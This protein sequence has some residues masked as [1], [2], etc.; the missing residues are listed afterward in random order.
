MRG[1]R[2]ESGAGGEEEAAPARPPARRPLRT[3]TPAG[4]ASG[5]R[6]LRALRSRPAAAGGLGARPAQGLSF[7]KV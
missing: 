5:R 1:A 7:C 4:P 6:S 2:V 3:C